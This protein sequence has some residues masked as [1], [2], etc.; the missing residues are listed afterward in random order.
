LNL[1]A[2]VLLEFSLEFAFSF[3]GIFWCFKFILHIKKYICMNYIACMELAP[4]KFKAFTWLMALE[5]LT[6]EDF[7]IIEVL[8]PWLQSCPLCH[9]STVTVWQMLLHCREVRLLNLE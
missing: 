8:L 5:K 2:A 7:T 9:F 4:S 6:P 3:V 1:A